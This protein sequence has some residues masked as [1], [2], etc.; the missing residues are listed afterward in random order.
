M[1]LFKNISDLS[2][3]NKSSLD[4]Y[5]LL[6]NMNIKVEVAKQHLINQWTGQLNSTYSRFIQVVVIVIIVAVVIIVVVVV[7][8]ISVVW[9]CRPS[10]Y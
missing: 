2:I 7:I 5:Y 6:I 1:R 4:S 3:V 10:R 8:R 9:N